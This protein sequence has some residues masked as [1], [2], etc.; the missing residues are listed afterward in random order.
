MHTVYLTTPD[1]QRVA[2]QVERCK[3]G[4]YALMSAEGFT[5]LDHQRLGFDPAPQVRGL[6]SSSDMFRCFGLA[7]QV[8]VP[9]LTV[10]VVDEPAGT[11]GA[12]GS[13][14]RFIAD[15]LEQL[16][17]GLDQLRGQFIDTDEF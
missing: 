6:E 11:H 4:T 15:N 2:L 5:S 13:D 14:Y 1:N 17:S 16:Q 12:P 9:G 7:E 10:L 8:E 3:R